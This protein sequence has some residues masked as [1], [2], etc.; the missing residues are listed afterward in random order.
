MRLKELRSKKQISQFELA[1]TLNV[2][3]TTYGRYELELTEPNIETL[4]NL[5]DYYNVTLDY[6]IG[7]EYKNEIGYLNDQQKN[8]VKIVQQLNQQN[9]I[10][11]I[12]YMSG[13][14]V[15]Q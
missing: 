15:N 9:L 5:A 11:A 7:R 8:A 14:L 13:L 3:Q 10:Q 1:K 6:L 12:A 4:C 2:T